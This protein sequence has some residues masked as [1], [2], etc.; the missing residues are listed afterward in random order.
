[1][2]DR[3][4]PVLAL[5]NGDAEAALELVLAVVEEGAQGQGQRQREQL[6]LQRG[7]HDPVA[8]HGA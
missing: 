4:S 2:G 3:R 6:L 5:T 1:M 7:T 8:V